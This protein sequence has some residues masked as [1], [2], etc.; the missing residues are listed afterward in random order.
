VATGELNVKSLLAIDPGLAEGVVDGVETTDPAFGLPARWIAPDTRDEAELLGYN[1]VEPVAVLATHLTEVIN[2]HAAEL[3]GRQ[4][5][6]HLLDEFKTT[7]PTVV[8]ELVP[9][10]IPV[11]RLQR[12]LQNLLAE[13]VPVRDFRT[14]LETLAEYSD[15]KD[16]VV[17][18]EYARTALRRSICNNLLK[19]SPDEGIAVLTI[20]SEVEQLIKDAAITTPAGLAVAMAPDLAARLL[21]QI[22]GLIANGQQPVV[23]TAPNVRLALRKLVAAN[24][25]SLHL[26]S[27]NEII[28]ELE[29][30]AVGVIRMENEDQEI[31]GEE[32]ATSAAP[33]P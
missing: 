19:E 18:T 12:V 16:V 27:Y 32:Y 33:G 25:P 23:L 30:S 2:S 28:P 29:V 17:L 6:Q 7:H 20:S 8:E 1:V 3:M 31:R 15:I 22:S 21:Q 5:T 24:F 11:G 10:V 14:L 9:D 13:R 4:E 26:L